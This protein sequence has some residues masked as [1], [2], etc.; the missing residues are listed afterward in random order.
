MPNLIDVYGNY[1]TNNA[2]QS[3][4]GTGV[5]GVGNAN[6]VVSNQYKPTAGTPSGAGNISIT[7]GGPFTGAGTTYNGQGTGNT[8]VSPPDNNGGYQGHY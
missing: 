1:N 8:L 4:S 7:S 3:L 5:G 6:T 2:E